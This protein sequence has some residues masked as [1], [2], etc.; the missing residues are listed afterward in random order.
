MKKISFVIPCYGSEDTVVRVLDE[1]RATLSERPEYS[2]EIICINDC[3]PD[4]VLEK[5]KAE[6]ESHDDLTVVD[7]A[8]NMG[9]HSAIMAGYARV[10]GDLI[11][12]MDD[13]GQCPV[14]RLWLMVDEMDKG[15]DMVMAKYPALKQSAF[16][17]LGSA[18]NDFMSRTLLGKPKGL[19]FSN[20]SIIRRFVIDEIL[21]YRNPYPYLEGLTL[22]VTH[23]IGMVEMEERERFAGQGAF[24]FTKSLSLLLNGFTAFS[25][26]PLRIASVMGTIIALG[27][28]IFGIVLIV[29]R[30]T[31]VTELLGWSSTM[32]V[33]LFIGGVLMMMIGLIGEYIGRIYISLNNS[34]QYVIRDVYQPK[35]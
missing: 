17:R 4:N 7:L 5:L 35:R 6:V 22:R 20:F 29:R 32:A 25:V 11:V 15:F 27:G 30:L 12:T 33:L 2:Y 21:Q 19:H 28:F 10:A 1:I 14:D 31:G 18:A 9:K 34:P 13:D 24:T 8:K 26:K 16:K 23:R 3:S